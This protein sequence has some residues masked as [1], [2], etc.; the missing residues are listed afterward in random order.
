[1]TDHYHESRAALYSAQQRRDAL[2]I[3]YAGL[4]RATV[5]AEL[6]QGIG[7]DYKTAEIHAML[8]IVQR[9]ND[10]QVGL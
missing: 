10:M 7:R 3:E 6:H 9:L 2:R 5:V 1:M 8:A 4:N